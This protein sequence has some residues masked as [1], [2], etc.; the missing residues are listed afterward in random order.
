MEPY[1]EAAIDV[2]EAAY[3]LD[4]DTGL[5]LPNILKSGGR[6][7]DLGG[8][9]YGMVSI[10]RSEEGVPLITQ[11]AESPKAEGI[12]MRV[13]EAAKEVGPDLV[14]HTTEALSGKVYALSEVQERFPTA[15]EAIVRHAGCKDILSVTAVDPDGAGAHI[16]L[17]ATETIALDKRQRDFWRMIEVHLA[18]GHRL[19]RGF[20]QDAEAPNVPMTEI[21]FA[22][23][24]LLDPKQLTITHAVGSAQ[25]PTARE[26]IR[27]AAKLLD[28]A[29]GPLRRQ[30]PAEALRLWKGLVRGQ[31]TLVDWFDSDGRRF[32]LAKRNAPRVKDPR[33]LTKREAQVA[34]YAAQGESSKLIGYRLGLSQSYVSRLL[35]DIMRKLGVKSQ[36]QLVEKMRGIDLEDPPAA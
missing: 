1:L 22:A 10:G 23:E 25:A 13:T 35:G 32:L 30:E 16:S 27:E 34:T 3:D 24:A 17:V 11:I 31:W 8:G 5:W 29:R 36:A 15:Y 18:A 7:F 19:R 33:G 14:A 6:L 4:V 12:A 28:K 21:P 20:G 9:C 2:V 26:G